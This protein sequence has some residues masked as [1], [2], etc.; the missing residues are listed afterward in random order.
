MRRFLTFL[1][2]VFCASSLARGSAFAI[3][4]LGVRAQG[5]GG[6]FASIADDGSAIF[7][8]P[9]GL[10]FQV[11][12]FM[13]MDSLTVVGLF[14]FF[15]TDP[16]PGVITPPNG[17]S[18]SVKPHFIPVANLYAVRPISDK[19]VV[20]FGGFVPFGLAA[21]FTNFNDGDPQNTKFPGRFAGSRAALQSYWFQPTFSYKVTENSGIGGGVA[22][23]H[24]HLFLEESILNPTGD[25]DTFGQAFAS[26][27]FPGIDPKAA[28]ASI[29]RLL[30]E[31]R[32]RAA[33]TANSPGFNL[34]YL[35]K[36]PSKKTSFGLAW[37][38]AVVSHLSGQASFAFTNTG[39]V[40][41]F[42]PAKASFSTLFPNQAIKGVFTTPGTYTVG[43]SNESI[44]NTLISVDF[45]VQDF[46][47][48]KDLPINFSQ[49]SGTA[50][51]P[52]QRLTF[53]FHNSYITHVGL[54]RQ[55]G[56]NLQARFGYVYDVSPVP[57]QSVGPL[58]PDAN[59]HSLTFGLTQ[60][61][62]ATELSLFYQAMFFVNRVTDVAANNGQYTN[63]QYSN[64]AH[65]A[66]LGM[67]IYPGQLFSK[68]KQ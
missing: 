19:L 28:A 30:P 62:G 61:R 47:R 67:R 57:D 4:E 49:T 12:T 10:A 1:L 3:N 54:Q 24:T 21:N 20:G 58:F 64:F 13:E 32:L 50:T 7:Y 68:G 23:V 38:S 16:P 25:G 5:M 55:V 59:R 6:A 46:R 34:G 11:R 2:S 35:Y 63:G 66:G 29:A 31:G 39:A 45:E 56:R 51:P 42:L 41:P 33:A 22:L 17:Y 52:E 48:F 43:V 36:N 27:V 15:P 37:R 14:R 60:R 18:G 26:T 9:A 40:T 65:L 44:R 53:N 8:N